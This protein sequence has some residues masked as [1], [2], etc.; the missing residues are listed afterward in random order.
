ML[1]KYTRMEEADQFKTALKQDV[2]LALRI[3]PKIDVLLRE[4]LSSLGKEEIDPSIAANINELVLV[5]LEKMMNILLM[6][7]SN[8]QHFETPTQ[9]PEL[10]NEREKKDPKAQLDNLISKIEGMTDLDKE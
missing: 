10:L 7:K 5:E 6:L 8:L 1:V 4:I 2:H 9:E 3:H